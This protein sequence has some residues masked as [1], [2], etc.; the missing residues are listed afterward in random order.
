MNSMIEYTLVRKR[1]KNVYIQIKDGKVIVKA[2]YR[3]SKS[4][5]DELISQK[6]DWISKRVLKNPPERKI[7]TIDKNY[8]YILNNKINIKYQ[9][10]SKSNII[11]NLDEN[12]CIV[13]LPQSFVN[14]KENAAKVNKK[15]DNELKKLANKYIMNAMEKY[16][17][18]TGLTPCEIKIR[19]FKSIWGNCSSKKVIKINQNLIHYGIDQIEYVC[20]HEITHLKYMNHQKKFWN[21]VKKYMPNYKEISSELKQ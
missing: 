16:I 10:H 4:K 21:F 8:I 20:L 7:D 17:A 18:L 14:S 1:I 13:M 9:K 12:T 3:I 6:R 15:I 5:I 11:V 2:P 19:K